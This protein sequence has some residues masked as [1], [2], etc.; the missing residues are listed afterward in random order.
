MEINDGFIILI[1]GLICIFA[2]YIFLPLGILTF[3][4]FL[5]FLIILRTTND[6]LRRTFAD[7]ENLEKWINFKPTT[8]IDEGIK[9]FIEWYLSYYKEKVK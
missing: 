1:S 4:I 9:N 5:Y 2:V 6:N 8:S 3:L 7:T